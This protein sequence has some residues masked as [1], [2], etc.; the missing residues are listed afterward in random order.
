MDA[1]AFRILAVPLLQLAD[2]RLLVLGVLV[3]VG[4]VEFVHLVGC[5]VRVVP[6]ELVRPVELPVFKEL[7]G[8]GEGGVREDG[9][10]V[11][12]LNGGLARVLH[13]FTNKII[14]SNINYYVEPSH[15][16]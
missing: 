14:F 16:T 12:V 15:Y 8:L 6:N 7:F 2:E 4:V 10:Q 3:V 13:R 5:A 9:L 11:V 1:F